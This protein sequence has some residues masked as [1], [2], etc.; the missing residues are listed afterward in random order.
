VTV[1]FNRSKP[2]DTFVVKVG[3]WSTTGTKIMASFSN[4]WTS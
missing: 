3:S 2:H 1:T 4:N